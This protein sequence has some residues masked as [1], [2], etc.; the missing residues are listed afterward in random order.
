MRPLKSLQAL[1]L[2]AAFGMF[3]G[4]ASAY[5]ARTATRTNVN[6]SAHRDVDVNRNVGV[7]QDVDVNRN[8]GV[9]RDVDV[10]RNVGVDRD[11]D[12]HVD[13]DHYNHDNDHYHHPVAAAA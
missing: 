9:D 2:V 13:D 7:N 12:V 3:T 6:G 1:A 5:R 11:V 4:S 10:N 8:V